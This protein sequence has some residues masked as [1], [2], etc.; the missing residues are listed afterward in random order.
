[1]NILVT[2]GA[3]FIGSN[4]VRRILDGTLTGISS[5]KVLD[6]LTYAGNLENFSKTELNKFELIK[7]DIC[8]ES[9]VEKSLFN[10]DAVINFAAETHVDRSISS[11]GKFIETNILG[12]S[13]L[14]EKS[15]RKEIN[16]FIQISTDEVYGSITEGSSK[17]SDPL[18]PNSPYS[19]SK[20]SADLLCRSYYRTYG[21][22]TKITRCSNN[23]GPFQ[24]PE[25]LIPFFVTNLINGK[26]LPIYG[27]GYNYRDWIHVDDHCEA[28]H[29]VLNHGTP[30][31]IY[32]IGSCNE[33]NNIEITHLILNFFGLDDTN[34]EFINDRK[35]HDFRYSVNWDK[36]NVTLGYSPK[37]DFSTGFEDTLKW[38]KSKYL[39]GRNERV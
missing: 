16:N 19:A 21:F 24:Y 26:K 38:Y 1:M 2:G 11:A 35:G 33:L 25:K 31:E 9:A 32:N 36:I 34:I 15:L 18:L 12:T 20:A 23:Y 3:G 14:L 13:V 29:K 37:V 22:N 8:D 6:K 4:Y 17:E 39:L 30:G 5:I 7:A 28:I 27:D 10:I